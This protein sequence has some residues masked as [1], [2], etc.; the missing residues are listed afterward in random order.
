M[1]AQLNGCSSLGNESTYLNEVTRSTFDR[2]GVLRGTLPASLFI[3]IQRVEG[4][5]FPT[6]RSA[7]PFL[8]SSPNPARHVST[9]KQSTTLSIINAFTPIS[10]TAPS[11]QS[12]AALSDPLCISDS[13]T[14]PY[15]SPFLGVGASGGRWCFAWARSEGRH[16]SG[17]CLGRRSEDIVRFASRIR[18]VRRVFERTA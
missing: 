3:A 12:F 5:L 11:H 9:P 13:F 4:P 1:S 2:R 16:R 8:T 7:Y 18:K 10:R 14:H 17:C 6:H 15:A